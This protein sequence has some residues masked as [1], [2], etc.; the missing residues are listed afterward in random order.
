MSRHCLADTQS[1]SFVPNRFQ[2]IV[3][4]GDFTNGVR[5]GRT[6]IPRDVTC[7]DA[8]V[9]IKRPEAGRVELLV[10]APGC[11]HA[12]H[13]PSLLRA[14]DAAT[15]LPP[16]RATQRAACVLGPS[17]RICLFAGRVA[18]NLAAGGCAKLSQQSANHDKRDRMKSRIHC[19]AEDRSSFCEKVGSGTNVIA[20]SLRGR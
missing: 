10:C 20:V 19:N 4:A 3:S 8:V 18:V 12:H 7:G 16:P 13:P 9:G 5:P 6:S 17:S 2:T 1:P 14:E 11:A 15:L